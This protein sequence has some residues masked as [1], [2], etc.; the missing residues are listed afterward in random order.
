MG[1]LWTVYPEK[2]DDLCLDDAYQSLKGDSPAKIPFIV[3]LFENPKSFFALPGKIDL[4]RHDCLHLL[5]KQG[6]D[7]KGE[8]YVLGF[9]MGNDPKTRW[10]HVLVF[11]AIAF[12]LYPDPYR[13]SRKDFIDFDLGVR[14]G[15]KVCTCGLNQFDF[16]VWQSL[17]LKELREQI[18]LSPQLFQ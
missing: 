1:L 11:K 16:S 13:L 15:Q 4:Y 18:G 8:A 12:F 6:F 2:L 9:T 14:H 5:L 17:S 7:A 10:F 3:W